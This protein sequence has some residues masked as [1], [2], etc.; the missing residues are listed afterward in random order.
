[1]TFKDLSI[2]ENEIKTA[3][4][5]PEEASRIFRIIF[6]VPLIIVGIWNE[7]S[8]LAAYGQAN[9]AVQQIGG[10]C[11]LILGT[12]QFILANLLWPKKG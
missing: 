10:I 4:T 8:G 12:L 11:L 9:G 6:I 3:R 7:F 5:T 2:K 1:M